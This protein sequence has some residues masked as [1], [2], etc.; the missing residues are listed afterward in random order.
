MPSF[1]F[2]IHR[3]SLGSFAYLETDVNDF[4]KSY[5]A[6]PMYV[7]ATSPRA[8]FKPNDQDAMADCVKEL[9][10]EIRRWE[11][12]TDMRPSQTRRLALLRDAVVYAEKELNP[13]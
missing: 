6:G 9:H 13:V 11:R 2:R 1:S 12:H 3:G 5:G 4:W 8:T 7:L 10:R